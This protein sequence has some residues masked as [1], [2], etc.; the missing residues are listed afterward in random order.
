MRMHLIVAAA[1]CVMGCSLVTVEQDPFPPLK[2][3]AARPAPPPPHIVL[4]ESH[5]QISDRVE[6]EYD[7]AT[8]KET[9]HSLLDEVVQVLESE[10]QIKKIQVEGY[11]DSSGA[12]NHNRKLSKQRADAVR[13]YII[14]KGIDGKRL[15]T[16]G[17]G[18]DDPIADNGTKEGRAANR[19]VE[20]K[21]LEQGPKETLV[22][23]ED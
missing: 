5:I 22:H 13:E 14:G 23:D 21:I 9:S 6:F 4:T 1:T 8:L 20:F 18:P 17:F 3:Q 16:K 2:I 12:E 15:V 10:P 19:R 7:S 11:T